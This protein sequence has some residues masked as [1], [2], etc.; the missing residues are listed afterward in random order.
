MFVPAPSSNVQWPTRLAFAGKAREQTAK[1]NADKFRI[2]LREPP[3]TAF[4]SWV[5]GGSSV[6][7]VADFIAASFV[8][9]FMTF[10]PSW[11]IGFR[12]FLVLSAPLH[13]SISRTLYGLNSR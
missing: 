3:K 8:G 1:I 7:G 5:D 10:D 11:L 9:I 4:R 13:V 12:S 6:C 2:L